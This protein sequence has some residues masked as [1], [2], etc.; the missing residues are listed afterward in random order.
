MPRIPSNAFLEKMV[1]LNSIHMRT[2]RYSFPIKLN[3]L[4][5]LV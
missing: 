2:R 1:I 3:K 5:S 4:A